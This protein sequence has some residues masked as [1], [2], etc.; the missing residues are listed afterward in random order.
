MFLNKFF[1]IKK[2]INIPA[3][4]RISFGELKDAIADRVFELYE[5]GQIA[6]VELSELCRP[7]FQSET[8]KQGE[9]APQLSEPAVFST[10]PVRLT[11]ILRCSYCQSANEPGSRFCSVCGAE[12]SELTTMDAPAVADTDTSVMEGTATFTP[13]SGIAF[14]EPLLDVLATQPVM[15]LAVRVDTPAIPKAVFAPKIM[16]VPEHKA[17]HLPVSEDVL[18]EEM[19]PFID[20][21]EPPASE[22]PAERAR[23]VLKIDKSRRP[24][25][26]DIRTPFAS[27]G[28]VLG[29]M[30]GK[31]ALHM[32]AYTSSNSPAT[33]HIRIKEV[34]N[35][36]VSP[37]KVIQIEALGFA[38]PQSKTVPINKPLALGG[39]NI[40]PAPV[41][42][43][44]IEQMPVRE[45]AYDRPERQPLKP[46]LRFETD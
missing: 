5:G 37:H 15:P 10:A 20:Y 8:P 31:S 11:D 29:Q 6:D 32:P 26:V 16:P 35:N 14:D 46:I 18:A 42:I 13:D 1:G 38:P 4:E 33:R 21:Q 30:A 43:K 22:S 23:R 7:F 27:I 12:M 45:T 39:T 28:S 19:I 3:A 25:R 40:T 17:F 34:S 9:S 2:D 24:E 41:T 36:I 44:Q